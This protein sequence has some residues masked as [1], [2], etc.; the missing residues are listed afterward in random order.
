M[1]ELDV[2]HGEQPDMDWFVLFDHNYMG[3]F[4]KM[5]GSRNGWFIRENPTTMDDLGG[6][7]ILGDSIY[8]FTFGTMH[9]NPNK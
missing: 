1:I 6:T 3:G 4:L 5:G 9:D 2:A 8:Q 7:P